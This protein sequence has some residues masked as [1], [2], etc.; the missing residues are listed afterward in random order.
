[1]HAYTYL[2]THS[3]IHCNL[4]IL[5]PNLPISIAQVFLAL[6]M[7]TGAEIAVKQ[8]ELH[9]ESGDDNLKARLCLCFLLEEDRGICASE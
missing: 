8:V 9:P 1:M 7:D 4:F 2:L 5:F 6:D 3:F